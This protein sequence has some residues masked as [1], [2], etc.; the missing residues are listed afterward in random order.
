M[1]IKAFALLLATGSLTACVSSGG[2]SSVNSEWKALNSKRPQCAKAAGIS[3]PYSVATEYSGGTVVQVF[4]PGPGVSEAQAAK[5][6][7]C[8]KT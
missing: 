7:A 1:T 6:N 4:E 3:G 8:M 5:A 2:N